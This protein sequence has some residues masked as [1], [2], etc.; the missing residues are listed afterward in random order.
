[1][2][3][4]NRLELVGILVSRKKNESAIGVKRH[5]KSA[6]KQLENTLDELFY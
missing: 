1:M 3:K 5:S 6:R 4:S 2:L